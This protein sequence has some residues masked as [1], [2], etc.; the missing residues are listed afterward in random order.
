MIGLVYWISLERL[1]R[2]DVPWE[3]WLRM[4]RGV[5]G[6]APWWKLKAPGYV[7]SV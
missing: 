5:R 4:R 7:A 1:E 6:I 2:W 3:M